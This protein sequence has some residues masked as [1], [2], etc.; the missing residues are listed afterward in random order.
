MTS[1]ELILLLEVGGVDG[2]NKHWTFT[3]MHQ[4]HDVTEVVSHVGILSK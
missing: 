4:I 2:L 3:Q 1:V